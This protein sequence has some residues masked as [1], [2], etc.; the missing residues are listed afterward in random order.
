MSIFM[1]KTQSAYVEQMRRFLGMAK[2]GFLQR[3]HLVPTS[4]R[5]GKAY[6]FVPSALAQLEDLVN[7][8]AMRVESPDSS[9]G[10]RIRLARD[11]AFRTDADIG[12]SMKVSREMVRRWGLGKDM[13]TDLNALAEVLGVPLE[14][15]ISGDEKALK[16]NSNLGA[17]VGAQAQSCR[18]NLRALTMQAVADLKLSAGHSEQAIQSHLDKA[19]FENPEM[20]SLARKAGGRWQSVGGMLVFAPWVPV[21]KWTLTS[22]KW[23]DEV[24]AIIQEELRKS[25]QSI[26]KAWAQMSQRCKAMGLSEDEFPRRI[27]LF[28]RVARMRLRTERFGVNINQPIGV[29][30]NGRAYQ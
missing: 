9:L 28:K 5:I 22:R 10:E 14:W 12:R 17:R 25:D 21:E 3:M 16:A 19:V 11:Y 27:T 2:K 29:R 4:V 18:E 20:A 8:K 26:H 24:E 23:S 6:R 30:C 7:Q 13:P 1:K 15:L